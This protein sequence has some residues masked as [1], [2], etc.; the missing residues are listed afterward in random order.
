M[1]LTARWK[2]ITPSDYAWEREALEW[3]REQLP[4]HEPYRAWANFEFVALDGSI[5][6]VDMLV[7]TPKACYLVEIK[8]H[9]GVMRGDAGTWL[10]ESPDGRRKALD[11]PRLLADRK[12]K[13]LAS[14][15]Q[16]QPSSRKSRERIPFINAI[17]FL[18]AA[19]LINK[20]E[21]PASLGVCTRDDFLRE[22]TEVGIG[23]QH[24]SV[25][26][27]V[28]KML[29]RAVEE[30]GI[31]ESVRTRRVG[32]YELTELLD[33]SD[34]FQDW[35]ARHGELGTVRKVR[36]Y[37][38]RNRP[39]EEAQRLRRAAE[40]ECR[41]LEGIEHPG[42]L[43]AREYQQHDFGPAL[44][45]EH[46][47][48]AQR[49]DHLLRNLGSERLDILQAI[50]IL[51]QTAEAVRHAHGQ[52]LYHRVLSPQ[53]IYVRDIGDGRFRIQIANWAT[54]SRIHSSETQQVSALS[55]LTYIV[56]EE[57]GPYVA[58]E[59]HQGEGDGVQMDVFSL[60]AIAFHLFTGKKPAESDLA[61]QDRLSRGQG[62]QVTDELNGASDEMQ[63]L[64]Q[65]ATHPDL[66]K[67]MDSVDEFL[68]VLYALEDELTRPE[69]QRVHAPTEAHEGETFEGGITVKK[70]LGRGA[71]SVVFLVEFQ[72]A[73]YV[74][75]IA[76]SHEHNARLRDEA[77]T[78]DLLRHQAIVGHHKTLELDGHVALLID[79]ADKGTLAER[80]RREGPVQ[81]ELLERFGDDLLSAL[82]QL[83]DK[84]IF[85]RDVKPENLGLMTQG[86]QLHLVLF[87]F[88]LAGVSADNIS[89]G[90]LAYMDPF[91]RDAGRR[92]WDDYAERFAAALTLYEMAA[93]SLPNWASSNGLPPLIEGQLDID[94]GV[95]DPAIRDRMAAFFRKALARDV[96]QRYAN[97]EEMLRAWRMVFVDAQ[98]QARFV[99][100]H[101]EDGCSLEEA[102]F[103]T[104]IGLLPLSPQ[105]LDAL[106]R[107][108]INTVAELA[109]LSRSKVRVW[110]GVGSQTRTELSEVIG[111]LQDR[112]QTAHPI[113][114]STLRDVDHASIDRLFSVVMPKPAKSA[115]PLRQK[116]LTEYLGRLEREPSSIDV[117]AV[118]WPTLVS[119]SAHTGIPTAEVRALQEK[120]IA[121]WSRS[122]PFNDLRDEIY[123]VL[124]ANGGII[125]AVELAEALLLGRG[126]L[127]ES[128]WREQW[129]Q[130]VARAAVETELSRQSARWILRRV[131]RRVVLADNATGLG[132]ELA[133]YAE[134]LGQLADE[135][136]DAFELLSPTRVLE[137]IRAVPA[138]EASVMLGNAR[139]LRLA[140]AVSQ[141]AA[142]SSRAELYP[143]GM[144]AE[145]AL[146]LAQGAL[147]GSRALKVAD[148][149]ARVQGRYPAAEPLP[150]RP[151][152]DELVRGLDIGLEWDGQ[153]EHQGENSSRGAYVPPAAGLTS[154][155]STRITRTQFGSVS[156]GEAPDE[157]E[158]QA[159][160]RAIRNAIAGRRFLA[161]SV[162]PARLQQAKAKLLQDYSLVPISFDELLLRHLHA[163][164][165]GMARPPDWSV[166]LKADAAPPPSR[167]WQNLQRL[168]SRVLPTM[169]EEILAAAGPVLLTEPGLL[170]RYDLVNT[171]LNELRQR[172]AGASHAH[173]LLLLI[174]A[175]A[176]LD[177]AHIDGIAVPRGA[178]SSEWARIP[179][180][181]LEPRSAPVEA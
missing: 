145:R 178:G 11:N 112:L 121:T 12:A 64:V 50:D 21:G 39:Q 148:V 75:K 23:W 60:G 160:D 57:A 63:Y 161:L 162:R 81:M 176:H 13:K 136:A 55:H 90:T 155:A 99:T 144:K 17:V 153:Y 110:T 154:I 89:A 7:L 19:N 116:F 87:D 115:D 107:R 152:L 83:E 118:H 131:G 156:D 71:S 44:I 101:D 48:E 102:Q 98:V 40:L 138:P 10:W 140:A 52:K 34:Y 41:L 104:Q 62:L 169:A 134:A 76:A 123:E 9:P 126:S 173:A 31:K 38:V 1:T 181:W 150:G 146:E 129:A 127:Q 27:P 180:V 164:C 53:N 133:D 117:A 103:D 42:I 54:A 119:V 37:L 142:L 26:R 69:G 175:D 79:H 95:F 33:E 77:R 88:S 84:A 114:Q 94:P 93:G 139:L 149:Q 18:S 65:Y 168:V 157:A 111:Q 74:L 128:P 70:R 147:L 28:A 130:A 158:I 151:Q 106:S 49:L 170:A 14:L 5:N 132:E 124:N 32:L 91:I 179:G 72:G 167:D 171:W 20:L 36:V 67:R 66:S 92:R 25:D 35:L 46:D 61:L 82:L 100:R 125:T 143:I 80:I 163:L 159:L 22:I 78:L 166:V 16:A 3:I 8:S 108:N 85:H 43:K 120:V 73:E 24:R 45:Y 6:E 47:A 165:S 113:R 109:R 59:A 137:R 56:R 29:A 30:A 4:D 15:L 122:K 135:C 172:L 105:A 174:A 177:G 141:N 96:R 2:Q 51:R 97:A 58:L 86:S 68:H